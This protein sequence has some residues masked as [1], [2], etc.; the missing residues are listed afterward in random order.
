[1]FLRRGRCQL[2]EW[3]LAETGRPALCARVI[4]VLPQLAHAPPRRL[5]RIRIHRP[6]NTPIRITR[7]PTHEPL[8]QVSA[9]AQSVSEQHSLAQTHELFWQASPTPQSVF[10]Q[11]SL[12]ADARVFWQAWPRR[13]Q[14]SSSTRW[15]RR[16]SC[17][18]RLGRRRSRV[19][20][21]L[22]GAC[23]ADLRCG[24][25]SFTDPHVYSQGGGI[26]PQK[27]GSNGATPRIAK[28]RS[29]KL[30]TEV[31]D[32]L[33]PSGAMCMPVQ[34]VVVYCAFNIQCNK[35]V[36]ILIGK[37]FPHPRVHRLCLGKPLKFQRRRI[38][39][40]VCINC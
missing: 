21:A 3:M 7:D 38:V 8:W 14:C 18:G 36:S 40:R 6:R 10:E 30:K 28:E 39:P 2:N 32:R 17:S 12:G 27:G 9:G 20:A 11:H 26:Q 19:R 23:G 1:M 25:S 35:E 15:R 13:S 16:T 24:I 5:H 34:I 33:A 29:G 4:L 31:V 37:S 22:T